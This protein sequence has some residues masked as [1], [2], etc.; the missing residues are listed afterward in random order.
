MNNNQFKKLCRSLGACEK[1]YDSIGTQSLN[2]S[3]Q[4]CQRADWML[5][6]VSKMADKP[7][8]P[9]RKQGVLGA[10]ACAETALKYVPKGELRPAKAIEIARA[11][12]RGK[13]TIE[14]VRDGA[15]AAYSAA[16]S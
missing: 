5:W 10:C 9:T 13:A 3:W 15:Y 16:Y 12:T 11:W 6:L 14:Q 1:G 4:S 7:N 8:W 2:K